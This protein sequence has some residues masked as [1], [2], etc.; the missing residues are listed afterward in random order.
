MFGVF[1]AGPALADCPDKV[2]CQKLS[3][4]K[5]IEIGVIRV[6][7]CYKFGKGCR[8]WHCSGARDTDRD[9]CTSRC[10]RKFANCTAEHGCRAEFPGA[11]VR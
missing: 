6:P 4:R 10:I 9:Y 11:L 3:G 8:P 5:M 2:S 7:T 1:T